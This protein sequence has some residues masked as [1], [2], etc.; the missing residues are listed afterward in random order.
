[1][2]ID[3][4]FLSY[5]SIGDAIKYKVL[6][7]KASSSWGPLFNFMHIV[8][9]YNI[10]IFW[11]LAT[12]PGTKTSCLI[13]D[14]I[15]EASKE[16]KMIQDTLYLKGIPCSRTFNMINRI[17]QLHYDIPSKIERINLLNLQLPNYDITV[18]QYQQLARAF[19]GITSFSC[20]RM[21]DMFAN[22]PASKFPNSNN[23]LLNSMNKAAKIFLQ[24]V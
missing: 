6:P 14:Y 13:Y 8:N 1:M 16:N 15:L 3:Q 19:Y 10:P 9:E 12:T 21:K 23:F 11:T 18:N 2:K 7:G 20:R 22:Y 4:L 17:L 24:M 5:P